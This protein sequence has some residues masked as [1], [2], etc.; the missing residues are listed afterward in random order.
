QE[1]PKVSKMVSIEIPA[2]NEVCILAHRAR[3]CQHS[4]AGNDLA[5]V[6][7]ASISWKDIS[8]FIVI[9]QFSNLIHRSVHQGVIWQKVCEPDQ[10]E[11]FR[12]RHCV[13][14]CRSYVGVKLYQHQQ[15]RRS[16]REQSLADLVLEFERSLPSNAGE[17]CICG[18]PTWNRHDNAIVW[19][20]TRD[21]VTRCQQ[22]TEII[23]TRLVIEL[24]NLVLGTGPPDCGKTPW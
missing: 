8:D 16:L 23:Y 6:Q 17:L 9:R 15:A 10:A 7:Q 2:V 21:R 1:I 4:R 18:R 12:L 24:D 20:R 11:V 14:R 19:N 5:G 22:R 3:Q 13:L